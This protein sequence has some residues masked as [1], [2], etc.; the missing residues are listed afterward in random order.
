VIEPQ[1]EVN[2]TFT[3]LN[4]TDEIIEKAYNG[5]FLIEGQ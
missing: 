5:A 3:V 1:D 2:G 4:A